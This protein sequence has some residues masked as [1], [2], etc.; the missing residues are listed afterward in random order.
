M[1]M[2]GEMMSGEAENEYR[3]FLGEVNDRE[4][5]RTIHRALDLGVNFFDTAPAYGAGHSESLLGQALAG[6]RDK[7]I[8]STKFGKEVDEEKRWFG[9]YGC[10]DEVIGNIRDECEASL[11]RLKTD[12]IDLYHF[13]LLDFPM[14]RADEARGILEELVA[15][16]K[17]RFYGWSTNDPERSRLFAQGD[18]CAA[19]QFR[20]NVLEDAPEL[21][22]IC[23]EY[24]QAGIIRGPLASGF[25]TGKYTPD[26]LDDLLSTDDFRLN[27]RGDLSKIVEGS[28][29]VQGILRSDGRTLVQGSLAWIWARSNRTIPIPGFRTM[30]QVEENI[31]AVEFGPLRKEQMNQIE[32]ILRDIR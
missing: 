17:I 10:E 15:E 2:G 18:S 11:R 30:A 23:D 8:I 32:D 4:S 31:E 12:Y 19:I 14:D 20:L 29:A 7:A 13:H 1:A 28:A 25:L 9:R 22:A 16:G 3:F 26:N 5:I 24:D 27:Y 21:L 6:R